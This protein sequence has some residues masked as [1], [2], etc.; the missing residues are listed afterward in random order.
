MKKIYSRNCF[1]LIEL[2]ITLI[3]I[4]CLSYLSFKFYFK[5]PV[6]TDQ[7]TQKALK[8]EHIDTSNYV[9]TMNSLKSKVNEVNEIEKERNKQIDDTNI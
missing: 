1:A 6:V 3:I 2:L 4:S 5:R 8:E 9:T 7:E